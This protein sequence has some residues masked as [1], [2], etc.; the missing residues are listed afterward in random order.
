MLTCWFLPREYWSTSHLRLVFLLSWDDPG[1]WDPAAVEP[2]TSSE[3]KIWSMSSFDRTRRFQIIH[4][5]N[6]LHFFDPLHRFRRKL[7]TSTHLAFESFL[8]TSKCCWRG[9]LVEMKFRNLQSLLV[10]SIILWRSSLTKKEW[11]SGWRWWLAS[12]I[13]G[14]VWKLTF[15]RYMRWCVFRKVKKPRI[16]S[17]WIRWWRRRIWIYNNVSR[18]TM[19]IQMSG[20]LSLRLSIPGLRKSGSNAGWLGTLD[21]PLRTD[22]ASWKSLESFI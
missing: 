7:W 18:Y 6:Q 11:I 12:R 4:W 22:S 14:C 17:S 10:C 19:R 3:C 1:P 2:S 5:F 8:P 13:Q 9:E 21:S 16:E 15:P 20:G